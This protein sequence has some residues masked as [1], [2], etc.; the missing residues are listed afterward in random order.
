V[1]AG[2]LPEAHGQV[3]ARGG[4]GLAASEMNRPHRQSNARMPGYVILYDN[5]TGGSPRFDA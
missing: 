1:D 5:R 4:N 3:A 2:A